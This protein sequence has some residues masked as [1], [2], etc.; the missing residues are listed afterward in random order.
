MQ[1]TGVNERNA[2]YKNKHPPLRSAKMNSAVVISKEAAQVIAAAI[3]PQIRKYVDAHRAE[4]QAYL[5]AE[6]QKGG[7]GRK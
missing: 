1:A 3:R 5:Q 2:D 4:Y 6:G 7:E